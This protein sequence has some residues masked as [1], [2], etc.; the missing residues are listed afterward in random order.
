M[1]FP[2]THLPVWFDPYDALQDLGIQSGWVQLYRA[3]AL[4][5]Q[6][7][8]DINEIRSEYLLSSGDT[9]WETQTC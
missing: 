5:L 1:T 7:Q 8:V 3:E 2:S 4:F 6:Y 9:S